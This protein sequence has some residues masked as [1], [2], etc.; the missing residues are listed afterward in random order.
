MLASLDLSLVLQ[1]VFTA[2][3]LGCALLYAVKATASRYFVVD[4]RFGGGG[5]G[6]ADDDRMMPSGGGFDA[7]LRLVPEPESE[8]CFVCGSSGKKQCS[9]CKA[10]RYCSA[11]CQA[12][13]WKEDHKSKCKEFKLLDKVDSLPSPTSSSSACG[14]RKA[15]L[16]PARGTCK[17]LQQ[18]KKVLFP[19]D[20]F[21][22]L[23][24]WD[25]SGFPPCGLL[26]CG[27]SCFANVVLQCLACTRPLVAF[28]L[29]K[30]HSRK[31]NRNDWCFFCEFQSHIHRVGQSLHPFSPINILSRL[32][33]IGGNLG[34][35]KQ[36]DAHEFMRFAI[37]TMQSICL[38][39]FGGE[40]ALDLSTQETTLIQHIFGGHL[41]SQVICTECDKISYRYENMMDLTVEIQGDVASLEDCLDQFTVKEWLDGE[42]MY[43]CDGC[44]DYVRAWKRLTIHRAPNILTIALKRFQ[45][46]RFGK[47]NKRV[48]FPETLDLGPYMSE[49]GDGT[50]VYKLYAVVVHV[51]MLNASFFG[52]YI[53]YT[54]DFGGNWYRI[55]DCK[56]MKVEL[57]EVLA[58]GAYMLLYSRICAR[59]PRVKSQEHL[60]EA[61][62]KVAEIATQVLSSRELVEPLG[63]PMSANSIAA[64]GC[65]SSDASQQSMDSG[66]DTEM[67]AN[68]DSR[69]CQEQPEFLNL[70]NAIDASSMLTWENPDG[71][72]L[73]HIQSCSSGSEMI[74]NID[75]RTN[76]EEPEFLNLANTIDASSMLAGENPDGA[77]LCYIQSS[78]SGSGDLDKN[79]LTHCSNVVEDAPSVELPHGEPINSVLS[80][81]RC[82]GTAA[83][84]CLRPGEENGIWNEQDKKFQ[85]LESSDDCVVNDMADTNGVSIANLSAHDRGELTSLTFSSGSSELKSEQ[86][87]SCYPSVSRAGLSNCNGNGFLESDVQNSIHSG[88]LLTSS[89]SLDKA[90]RDLNKYEAARKGPSTVDVACNG[91]ANPL[92]PHE[93]SNGVVSHDRNCEDMSSGNEKPL[94][95]DEDGKN[96]AEVAHACNLNTN[97]NGYVKSVA[98]DQNAGRIWEEDE[99]G[100]GAILDCKDPSISSYVHESSRESFPVESDVA[101]TLKDLVGVCGNVSDLSVNHNGNVNKSCAIALSPFHGTR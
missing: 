3:A 28:L 22:K 46:G 13:H 90:S 42:N 47:L 44:S 88:N 84:D 101:P 69:T 1:F 94:I 96:P 20:E 33:N 67:T 36:E 21:V 99:N 89:L 16:V 65:P 58:Q 6:V 95:Y 64:P 100:N 30:G 61:E 81:A 40:K 31:C 85:L 8:V 41:Q 72:G 73:C 98:A 7:D 2:L 93:N 60:R 71:A 97:C 91:Y 9:R 34:Y 51:D 24:N 23:F 78:S 18:P 4:A 79:S 54:K 14:K 53:C 50:D 83:F 12:K 92:Y 76:Q 87:I 52:H 10:V 29:E 74:A 19:Y 38:N 17:V 62:K 15:S 82:S 80:I 77:G 35:G 27:N 63:I 5:A 37:D 55:D 68:I 86:E 56:V 25:T 26:N 75:S 59:Q 48:T 43:K 45:S 11:T 70:A 57:E 49:A 32:P 39:E 66:C